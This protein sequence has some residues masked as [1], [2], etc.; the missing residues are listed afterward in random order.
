ML[1]GMSLESFWDEDILGVTSI[2]EHIDIKDS[3]FLSVW[4]VTG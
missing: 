1:I 4:T 3:D 2:I